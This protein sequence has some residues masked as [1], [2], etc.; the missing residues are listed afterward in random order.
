[1][2]PFATRSEIVESLPD[3][4]SAP[5]KIKQRR[6][7]RNLG[8]LADWVGIA[9]SALSDF[10]QSP[11]WWTRFTYGDSFCPLAVIEKFLPHVQM[12]TPLF[13]NPLNK[14]PVTKMF[15]VGDAGLYDDLGH[16]PLLRRKVSKMVIFDTSAIHDKGSNGTS[17]LLQMT[18]TLAAFGQPNAH[19]G[20]LPGASNPNQ[21]KDFMTV[22]E[23]S[24]FGRL[25]NEVK[26][27][28]QANEPVIVR[29]NFTT[30]NNQHFGIVGG[31]R[32][33]I[34][35]VIGMHVA[36][37]RD[38][39]PSATSKKLPSYFPN[40]QAW[41]ATTKFQIG[42]LSQF[43]SWMTERA[44]NEINAMLPV[45]KPSANRDQQVFI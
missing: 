13:T 25:W 11:Q 21:P 28:K 35:W 20:C 16:L 6:V 43:G 23:P 19:F 32:V 9:T 33:E 39:L 42:A 3:E 4:A 2:E 27:L 7:F 12:W 17:D 24:D 8:G 38:A 26:R 40:Y 30:V 15:P 18:Y 14:V 44:L 5:M 36:E 1:V 22:F 10:Q 37:W 45:V 29:G 31:R 41:Q 34:V